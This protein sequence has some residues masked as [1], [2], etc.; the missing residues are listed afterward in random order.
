MALLPKDD[1]LL[2]G[3][4]DGTARLWDW[5]KSAVDANNGKVVEADFLISL[6]RPNRQLTTHRGPV[7]SVRVTCKGDIVTA[8]SDG[9]ILIWPK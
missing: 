6:V 7:T 9:T 1:R 8:S 2:T 4:A 5:Q 3:G